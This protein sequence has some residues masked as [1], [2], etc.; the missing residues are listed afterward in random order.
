MIL[1][2]TRLQRSVHSGPWLGEWG[3]ASCLGMPH[4]ATAPQSPMPALTAERTRKTKG[5]GEGIY[6]TVLDNIVFK[7]G[8]FIF[9]IFCIF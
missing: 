1:P 5:R 4:D 3:P 7:R 2:D 6:K 9:I 8:G